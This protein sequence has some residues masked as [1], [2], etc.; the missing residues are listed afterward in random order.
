MKRAVCLHGHFY[1]P[2]RENPWIEEV[3]V[4]DSAA[5][6][7]DWNERTAPEGYGPNAAGPLKSANARICDI[8]N[9]YVHLSFN[10]GPTLLAWLERQT[11]EIYRSV[12]EA[13]ARSLQQRGHGNAIAQAYNHAILPL[14]NERDLRT[15][16]RW[17]S[18]DFKPRF[19]RD[20][21]GMW[22][23]ETA[24]DVRT[25]QALHEEGIRFT[26]PTANHGRRAL[27][28][29][30]QWLAAAGARFDPARPYVV[31]LASG[32]SFPVFFYDGPIA[33]AVAFGEGLGSGED[34]LRRLE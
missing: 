20:P 6:F 3:E 16:S 25:L 7:H 10:F 1:Q 31:P 8:V 2:P 27:D 14:C 19:G 15:Q 24:A 21:E 9:N 26:A 13:D 23:P 18:A 34:L 33:R 12:L 4:Q 5:P 29:G 32:T 28:R 30:G 17:A 22:L 11:P